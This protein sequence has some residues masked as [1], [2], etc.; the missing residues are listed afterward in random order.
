MAKMNSPRQN[1]LIEARRSIIFMA[2][3][4]SMAILLANF[5]FAI[6]AEHSLDF[7]NTETNTKMTGMKVTAQQTF[8]LDGITTNESDESTYI[9]IFD[10]NLVLLT[11]ESITNHYANFSY[12]FTEGSTYYLLGHLGSYGNHKAA[13][14]LTSSYPIT[15]SYVNW[16]SSYRN[17]TGVAGADNVT[18]V[19]TI[20]SL[21]ISDLDLTLNSFTYDITTTPSS[22]L[23]FTVNISIA[24]TFTDATAKLNYN[25]TTYTAYRNDHGGN[26][27]GFTYNLTAGTI[28]AIKNVFWEFILTN[29]STTKQI[30]SS[31]YAQTISLLRMDNCTSYSIPLVNLTLYDEDGNYLLNGSSENTSIKL[32]FSL[33]TAAQTEISNYSFFFNETNPARVCLETTLG[34]STYRL[35]G[36]IEY[37]STG[38]YVEYYNFQNYTLNDSTTNLSLDLYNLATGSGQAFKIIYKDATF[39]AVPNAL[40]NIQR[41]YIEDGLFKTVERP[42]TGGEGY[43]IGH[44]VPADAIYNIIVMKHGEIL[45]TFENVVANCQNPTLFECEINLNSY[46]SSSLPSDFTEADDISFTLKYDETTRTITSLFVIPS[47]ISAVVSLNAT[48]ADAL[49]TSLVCSN[50]TKTSS[51]TLYCYVPIAFGNSTVIARLYKDGVEKGFAY[52][53]LKQPPTDIYGDSLVLLAMLVFLVF[54]GIGA[55]SDS[56]MAMGAAL[57]I[58]SIALVALNIVYSPSII[59]KGATVLWFI[60]SIGIVLIKGSNRQ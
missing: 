28:A 53:R 33:Q 36:V 56:P 37:G 44:L 2:L 14:G 50:G 48:Q 39:I 13:R 12:K 31:I 45:A 27:F 34:T 51:G 22:P 29:S 52:L 55:G 23:N 47:G 35:E 8:T 15:G 17:I 46:G 43:T 60:I 4:F 3:M 30:N 20:L 18:N 19:Y 9:S 58:G 5:V 24:S 11:K 57:I 59:G 10:S 49:G 7:E 38:R 21:N 26:Q 54:V 6:T 41:K 42:L 25:G 40:L 16:I 1:S 32:S